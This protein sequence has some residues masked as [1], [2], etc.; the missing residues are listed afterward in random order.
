MAIRCEGSDTTKIK[1]KENFRETFTL[2]LTIS[3]GES[4]KK[5]IIVTKGK[6][7]R[8]LKKFN[9]DNNVIGTYTK[10]SW[11]NENV[12]FIV[13]DEIYKVTKGEKSV[14]LMD[15]FDSHTTD[16]VKQCANNKN[17]YLIYVPNG[18]TSIFQPLDIKIN[19]II[20]EKAIQ[21][22]SNFKANNPNKKYNHEQ[23]LIDILEIIKSIF[24]KTI[25]NA[26]KCLTEI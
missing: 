1:C 9:L 20:K 17:I 8:C 14:L 2:G 3:L 6:T 25:I 5:P 24:K 19:G 4:F 13:L 16:N 12:I 21:K 7:N 23:C 22:F 18:M 10:S 15:K 11:A 26:F